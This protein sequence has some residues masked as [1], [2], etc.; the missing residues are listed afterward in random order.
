MATVTSY[1]AAQMVTG[2]CHLLEING[3]RLLIDC[4]MFQGSDEHKNYEPFGFDPTTIDYLL[5]THGHID[6]IGRVPKLVKEG[7]NGTIIS[8]EATFDIAYIMLLDAANILQE[9]FLTLYKKAR[10][11]GAEKSVSEPLYSIE[12]VDDTF[13]KTRKEAAYHTKIEL[14]DTISITFK[15]AGHILGSAFIEIDFIEDTLSKRVVFSGDI[16]SKKRL[17]IDGLEYGNRADTLY[18]ES[19]YGDRVHRDLE[20]SISEFKEVIIETMQHG[21]NVL[22]PSFALERTQE[23]LTLMKEMYD[24]GLLKGCKVFLDSPLAIK[25]TELYNRYPKLLNKENEADSRVG[26]NPFIFEALTLTQ[27]PKQSM[28]IN[29]IQ[30]RA[31]IIAGSGMCTGGRILHHFKHRLW[32]EKNALIFVGYQVG[33]TLGRKIIDGAEYIHVHGEKIAVKAKVHT[34]NGF[35]AHGDR[36]DMI[37]WIS[38]FDG[39]N[40]IYLIHGEEEKAKAFKKR[41]KERMDIKVHIVKEREH[42]YI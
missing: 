1:G 18:I 23:I 19:T 20:E 17:V 9:E 27:S 42:I 4:G 32:D 15:E 2:S 10:R 24:D 35:S 6:H 39:L 28:M 25:A 31:I 14:T 40:K 12:D 26:N 21:G 34:I 29:E 8:T 16:G 37:D 22:I 36:E 33:G 38:H 13:R 5:L 7:F 11:Q 3:V 41:I 30:S